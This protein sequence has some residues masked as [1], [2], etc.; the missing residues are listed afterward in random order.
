MSDPAPSTPSAAKLAEAITILQRDRQAIMDAFT[1]A[2]GGEP[3]S[4]QTTLKNHLAAQQ[5]AQAL[6]KQAHQEGSK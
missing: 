2:F 6:I 5:R 1:D 4:F 3:V